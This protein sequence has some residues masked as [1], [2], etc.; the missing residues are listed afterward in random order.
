MAVIVELFTSNVC[1]RCV[2]AKVILNELVDELG[3]QR[4]ELRFVDVVENIDH[5][6]EVGVLATP[7][8][9]VNGKLVFP[10]LPGKR[11]VRERLIEALE[12]QGLIF[13]D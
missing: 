4:V 13:T 7:A 9:A 2:Q 8:L 1:S 5:A 12:R 11:R 3:D 10:S 6:V